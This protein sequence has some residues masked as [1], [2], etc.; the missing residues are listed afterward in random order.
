MSLQTI[1][2]R[3]PRANP[4][5][6]IANPTWTG[7]HSVLLWLRLWRSRV[8]GCLTLLSLGG[9][10]LVGP[11][12]ICAVADGD[13]GGSAPPVLTARELAQLID[14]ALAARWQAEGIVPVPAADD[15]ELLRRLYL[16][17]TGKIP[18]YG[19]AVQLLLSQIQIQELFQVDL[20]VHRRRQWA[21]WP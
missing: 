18:S 3:A 14:E 1:K 17:L 12:R 16:D 11:A 5:G 8:F 6:R 10:L 20:R 4:V 7:W 21:L 19:E 2:V 9:L 13:A 15:A